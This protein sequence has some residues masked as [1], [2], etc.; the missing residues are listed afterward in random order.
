MNKLGYNLCSL[1]QC[2][3][4]VRAHAQ[5]VN[6]CLVLLSY[7]DIKHACS[8]DLSLGSVRV[9]VNP[10][11]MLSHSATAQCLNMPLDTLLV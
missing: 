4:N 1:F 10:R 11:D 3:N 7:C 5:Y 8:S 6:N 9:S 2:E